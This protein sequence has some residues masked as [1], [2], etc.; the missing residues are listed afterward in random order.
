MKQ[1]TKTRF[2][3]LGL[4]EQVAWLKQLWS[5]NWQVSR[6]KQ[7]VVATGTVH[8]TPLSAIYTVRIDYERFLPKVR[9]LSPILDCRDDADRLPHTFP[10]GS[11]CL[12]YWRF[13]EWTSSM[14]LATTIVPWISE[15]L[16]F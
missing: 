6:V 4:G 2:R 1:G 5:A 8:P 3:P 9:V 14:P 7:S 13:R 12:Y 15:W 10:D 11:L 16:Y